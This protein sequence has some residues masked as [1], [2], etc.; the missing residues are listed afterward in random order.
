LH[1]IKLQI[2]AYHS[3]VLIIPTSCFHHN[4]LHNDHID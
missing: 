4:K 2:K 3:T 1:E